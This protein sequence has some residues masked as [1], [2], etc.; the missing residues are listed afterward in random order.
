MLVGV[1]V[2]MNDVVGEIRRVTVVELFHRLLCGVTFLQAL[3]GCCMEG[4]SDP[5]YLLHKLS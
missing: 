5:A 3:I 1:Y 4:T 2:W